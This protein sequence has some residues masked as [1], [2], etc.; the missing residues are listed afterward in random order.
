M[1]DKV[2]KTAYKRP[3]PKG[4]SRKG[5]P[6]K[7]TQTAREAITLLVEANIPK[8]AGWLE[9]IEKEHGPLVAMKCVNDMIEF[10]VPKLQRTELAG[11]GGGPLTVTINKVA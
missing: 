1:D 5:I 10:A 3:Q 8:M 9:K 11:D 2:P 4:G 6:N 7:T